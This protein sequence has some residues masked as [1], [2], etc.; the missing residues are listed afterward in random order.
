MRSQILEFRLCPNCTALMPVGAGKCARCKLSPDEIKP[1]PNRRNGL[2]RAK[3]HWRERRYARKSIVTGLCPNCRAVIARDARRCS[4]CDWVKL[5]TTGELLSERRRRLMLSMRT[6]LTYKR[7]VYCT[8]CACNVH[9][10]TNFCPVCQNAFLFNPPRPSSFALV[11]ARLRQRWAKNAVE[12][13]TLCPT[14]DIYLPEWSEQCYCCGWE[15]PPGTNTRT[16][17][18]YLRQS[19][20]H[21]LSLLRRHRSHPEKAEDLCPTCD[22]YIPTSDPM[23]MICGWMPERRKSLRDGYHALRIER[24][25]RAVEA[26]QK[27]LRVCEHCD[28]PLLP[29]DSLCMVCG[30][31]P[32]PTTAQRILSLRLPTRKASVP[33]G[34][35]RLC[36]NCRISL[37][38]DARHCAQCGWDKDP[39]RTWA[40]H[41]KMIW[42]V[43]I[44]LVLYGTL[45]IT[46]LQLADPLNN[47]GHVDRYG[48][49]GMEGKIKEL[50]S[51]RSRK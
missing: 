3:A 15:R 25:R 29:G 31:K 30:W 8:Q 36:P 45:L 26:R 12:R 49:T 11:A 17:L 44:C 4:A 24:A 21:R 40:R 20:G 9:S 34:R 7:T 28:L 1:L 10:A 39:A 22:V 18:R 27:R 23:C 48:R 13:A 37:A 2:K 5:D 38:A 42:L 50:G 32:A 16:A 19:V 35:K 43:P 47:Y 6:A 46:F 41:P 33:V 51:A 14:C